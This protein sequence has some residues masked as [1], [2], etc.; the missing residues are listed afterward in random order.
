MTRYSGRQ[1]PGFY[2][3]NIKTGQPRVYKKGRGNLIQEDSLLSSTYSYYKI[4]GLY[5]KLY[6]E[7]WG[8]EL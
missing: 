5:K 4:T 7:M 8:I 6:S 3:K 1:P 2:L